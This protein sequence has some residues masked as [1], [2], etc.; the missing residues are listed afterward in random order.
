MH[1]LF[2]LFAGLSF[3]AM[4]LELVNPI[5]RAYAGSIL[6]IVIQAST[7]CWA[8][9]LYYRY[10][11]THVLI[12][13]GA[14]GSFLISG[15]IQLMIWMG[16]IDSAVNTI[17]FYGVATENVLMVLAIGYRI[18]VTEAAHKQTDSLLLHSFDQLSKVF[19]PHQI[20]Q[21]REGRKVEETMPVGERDACIL[22]FQIVGGAALMNESYEEYVENFMG[23]CRQLLMERYDPIKFCSDAYII[24]EMGDGFLCS[25]VYPFHHIG[26]L[27]SDAAVE[28]AEKLIKEFE[29][30]VI[31]LDAPQK[32]HCSV[33]I[34]Y[35]LVKSYFSR[36]GRIRDD[37]WGW[38]VTLAV[39]YGGISS[40]LFSVLGKDAGNVIILHDAVYESL[41]YGNRSGFKVL[42]LAE[43]QRIMGK[44]LNGDLIAYRLVDDAVMEGP[45]QA[46]AAS[47]N[48]A[49]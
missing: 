12:F 20:L 31:K 39:T 7:V 29:E 4:A 48:L 34:V 5:L 47:R 13:I 22:Y 21:I 28:L 36:S 14:F 46:E 42:E 15:F 37:L 2:L 8:V 6:S 3:A 19:Y 30:F 27:K 9:Y 35:G 44:D 24:R 11:Q 38:P 43:A 40:Q 33:G 25:V 32:I 1:R 16:Q 45:F 17:M 18:L 49:S 41:S 26:R 23:R 10:R